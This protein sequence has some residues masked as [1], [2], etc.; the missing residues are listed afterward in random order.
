[1]KNVPSIQVSV[2]PQ[3]ASEIP[4]LMTKL[5]LP[6]FKEDT[7]EKTQQAPHFVGLAEIIVKT[8]IADFPDIEE[9]QRLN[10]FDIQD[11]PD[12]ELRQA[13]IPSFPQKVSLPYSEI[14]WY[15]TYGTFV[16][17]TFKPLGAPADDDIKRKLLE[18][19]EEALSKKG[20]EIAIVFVV[21][22][23]KDM[24]SKMPQLR[25]HIYST[26]EYFQKYYPNLLFG[27][28]HK[29]HFSDGTTKDYGLTKNIEEFN[30][31]LSDMV[32]SASLTIPLQNSRATLDVNWDKIFVNS[33]QKLGNQ[34]IVVSIADI[35]EIY[36]RKNKMRD[37][38]WDESLTLV[39]MSQYEFLDVK[40]R[41]KLF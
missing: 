9:T 1:M 32:E 10:L 5:V 38:N 22:I 24:K 40:P 25:E 39:W 20:N 28:F 36:A 13:Q 30:R 21:N 34:K 4:T 16:T 29:Y 18:W 17:I 19:P 11:S 31:W 7:S 8:D 33:G 6:Y 14:Q 26:A 2:P 35:P 3:N 41:M 23:L 37:P 27:L 12:I 15:P